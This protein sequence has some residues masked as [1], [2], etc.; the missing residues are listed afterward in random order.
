M[1]EG[2][3]R[4]DEGFDGGAHRRVLRSVLG[5]PQL[6]A[7]ARRT[8]DA[9]DR[10][11][12]AGLRARSELHLGAADQRAQTQGDADD[13][14]DHADHHQPD[15]DYDDVARGDHQPD[16]ALC[17]HADDDLVRGDNQPYADPN[18]DDHACSRVWTGADDAGS[19]EITLS[20]VRRRHRYT[21][22]P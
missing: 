5:L 22:A 8:G 16:V 18:A 13:G 11:R 6:R 15:G 14:D 19:A 7:P 3:A 10:G 17:V 1:A 21:G 9:A 20:G 2:Q 12:P 4:P